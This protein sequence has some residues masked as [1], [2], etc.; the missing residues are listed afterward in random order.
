M[1]TFTLIKKQR[2]KPKSHVQRYNNVYGRWLS[3]RFSQSLERK[4][5]QRRQRTSGFDAIERDALFSRI[6]ESTVPKNGR[7]G[8]TGRRKVER[9]K[10]ETLK[11]WAIVASHWYMG[12]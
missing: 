5:Y 9:R 2:N 12:L 11:G 4:M 3:E 6:S 1:S 7:I 10:E 8:K